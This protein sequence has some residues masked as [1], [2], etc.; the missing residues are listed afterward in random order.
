MVRFLILLMLAT[1]YTVVAQDDDTLGNL[2]CLIEE[3][4]Y[5]NYDDIYQASS[6]LTNAQRA[7]LLDTYEGDP[8]YAM[9]MN[10]FVGLGIGSWVEGDPVGG[11][12]GLVGELA[13][14]GV[15]IAGEVENN[16]YLTGLGGLIILPTRF[17]A[18]GI[19]A[20]AVAERN[21][22]LNKALRSGE[23]IQA[24]LS[25]GVRRYVGGTTAMTLQLQISW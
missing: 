24:G 23:Q 9:L 21:R 10:G 15:V 2:E 19:G 18:A 20:V 1:V 22:I 4:V 3:S 11:W 5:S 13:G 7:Y 25:P 14:W 16:G 17:L 6:K 12:F 8:I